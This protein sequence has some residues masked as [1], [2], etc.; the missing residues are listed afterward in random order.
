[1]YERIDFMKTCTCAGH[2]E[3]PEEKLEYV[4]RELRREIAQAIEDGITI[5]IS[6]FSGQTDLLFASIVA[7]LKE[8]NDTLF[9]EA[10]LP[11]PKKS[12]PKDPL[13]SEL[14][15][16]CSGVKTVSKE[17]SR[18]CYF[19]H[20]RYKVLESERVI[21]VYDGREEGGTFKAINVARVNEKDLR[22]IPL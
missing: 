17:Y 12:K 14:I 19:L 3:I 6:G 1:M 2:R 15:G 4:T 16:K 13:Y 8:K 22:I 7:E 5:F 11:Y 18:D 10:A 21:A 9:L 20:I